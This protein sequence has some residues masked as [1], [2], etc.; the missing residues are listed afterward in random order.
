MTANP[1]DFFH[2]LFCLFSPTTCSCEDHFSFNLP[3]P[4]PLF[5]SPSSTIPPVDTERYVR[6]RSPFIFSP[7]PPCTRSHFFPIFLGSRSNS[8]RRYLFS[9]LD[10]P[11][12]TESA[13]GR[14]GRY[15]AAHNAASSNLSLVFSPLPRSSSGTRNQE[16]IGRQGFDLWR[17]T[18]SVSSCSPFFIGLPGTIVA[19]PLRSA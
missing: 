9:S 14:K 13:R 6:Y 15:K 16:R 19:A 4:S 5:P 18:P 12:Y 8:L 10:S 2:Q 11:L 7:L 1:R 3:L 17:P